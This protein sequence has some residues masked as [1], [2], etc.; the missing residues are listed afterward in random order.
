MR[1]EERLRKNSTTL[2][3]LCN[4]SH[5]TFQDPSETPEKGWMPQWVVNKVL[6]TL[7]EYRDKK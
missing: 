2:R 6:T 7:Q 4:R 1:S 5:K 3:V